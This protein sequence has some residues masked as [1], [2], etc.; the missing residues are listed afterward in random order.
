MTN[1][2]TCSLKYFLVPTLKTTTILKQNQIYITEFYIS[3]LLKI[4]ARKNHNPQDII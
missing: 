2:V 1:N 4:V 3:I